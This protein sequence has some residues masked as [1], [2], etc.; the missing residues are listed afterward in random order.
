M[1]KFMRMIVFFD[2]PVGTARERKAATKFRNFLIKD[3]YHENFKNDMDSASSIE[4]RI[5]AM[6][7]VYEAG[8]RKS[9]V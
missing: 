4:R 7:Q 2:L 1:S 6:K 9:V 8:D 5:A 3:G